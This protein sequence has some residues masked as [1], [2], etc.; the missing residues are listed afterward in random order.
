MSETV[1]DTFDCTARA[2]PDHV[3]LCAPPAAGRAYHPDGVEF[4]F[5]ET[6]EAALALRSAYAAA[7]YAHGHRV[8]LHLNPP[9]R[10]RHHQP[11]VAQHLAR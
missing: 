6:R 3:F 4:T 10:N 9:R 7:G 11:W 8:A 1:F 2:A 5:A